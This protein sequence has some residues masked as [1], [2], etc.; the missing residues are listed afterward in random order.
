MSAKKFF[1]NRSV[2]FVILLIGTTCFA[3]VQLGDS[4]AEVEEMQKLLI[5]KN[6]LS[7]EADGDFGEATENA[8]KNFQRDNGLDA[9]GICGEQTFNLLRRSN[10]T[11]ENILKF[12]DS[13][14]KVTELQNILIR[15]AYLSGEAD[16][17][18]G[19][20]TESA[21][22]SF[23]RDNDL[24]ADGICGEQ[25]FNLLQNSYSITACNSAHKVMKFA[26]CR[27]C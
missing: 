10:S 11:S 9:D 19:E 4:G 16:G 21:L 15:L 17:D 5:E 22:K 12:G 20:A 18:F 25:T 24:D 23:Q 2:F 1:L 6:Y 7:G 13:G 27:I 14:E 26:N 8:L 3:E